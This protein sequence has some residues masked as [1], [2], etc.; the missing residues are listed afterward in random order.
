ME[1]HQ[2]LASGLAAVLLFVSAALPLAAHAADSTP[3]TVPAGLKASAASPS[4]VNLSWKASSDNVGV[5]GYYVYL[6][7][8]PLATT[9]GTSFSHT[10]LT[11][12][13]KYNYRVSAYD[14][15]GNDSAWTAT[16]AATTPTGSARDNSAPSVPTG[17]QAGAASSSQINLSWNASKDN[18]GV[19]GYYVYLNDKPL[20]TTTGTSF[21]HTGLTTGATYS[22]RV[23]AYDGASNHSAWTSSVAATTQKA[24]ACTASDATPPSVPTGLRATAASASQVNLTWNASTDNVAVTGYYVYLND[25]PLA[26]TTSNSFAHTG[27][28]AGTAYNYRVSAYDAVPNHSAWTASVAATPST[29]TGDATND[30]TPPSVPSGLKAAAA[31]SSQINLSWNPS[32]DNVGV[33]GY[34]VYLND[35]PLTTT[36][37]NSFSHTGLTA[38]MAYNY[39]VSAYD[40]VPNHSAW[41][42]SVA[43]STS[44][45]SSGDGSSGG[46]E[47]GS[48]GGLTAIPGASG[49]GINTKAG[50]G[51]TVYKVTNLNASGS[52]SLKACVDASGPRVCVFEV[53]GTIY[54][55]S[56][57]AIRNP[58]IT[59]AG[60]TAPSPGVLL[61]GAGIKIVT[62]DVLLQHLRVRPGDASSGPDPSNRDAMKI[63]AVTGDTYNVVIDHVSASWSVDELFSAWGSSGGKIYNVTVR[64]SIFSEALNNSIHP[65]GAHP[66]GFLI[67]YRASRVT[68]ANNLYA[69]NGWRN[70]MINSDSTD[71]MIINNMLY[72]TR[73]FPTDQIDFGTKGAGNIPMRASVQGNH[74]VLAPGTKSINT[75]N[76]RSTAA[77]DFKIFVKDNSGP[78]MTSN[79]WSVV[80]TNGRSVSSLSASS[81]PIWAPG[82][83]AM[84]HAAVESYVLG[85]A[86]ARPLDRDAVDKRVVTQVKERRGGHIDSPSQVGGY[87]SLATNYRALTLP[88][89][90]NGLTESG[91]TNLEL[92]L[93]SMA[94]A[95]E[96]Q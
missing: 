29:S 14:A 67:G 61:R 16:V 10:G 60:Q 89:S 38:G 13:T 90:P 45:G 73:G 56:D 35:K 28:T 25:K 65:E 12:G 5:T 30:T 43:A 47:Q 70:P 96:G 84:P 53:S 2:T 46:V 18:I 76:I 77:S 6:N 55:T 21:A 26:T 8:K 69:F 32:T 71:V 27:L 88:A 50:R 62:H 75:I 94:K 49:F 1:R 40:A 11:A 68:L 20:A 33:T 51:G 87:P 72:R 52:G 63:E 15:A 93:H 83:V 48:T 36:T 24:A 80:Q 34:Y 57:L 23:S 17:L 82:A 44:G 9:A 39:R 7:G 19:T 54:L 22:Y 3:P 64:N 58:Y 66:A 4:Q 85:N 86:G 78:L 95:V 74:F 42:A 59:I 41:T 37:T 79:P 81:P 91:Y 31:S 92:W